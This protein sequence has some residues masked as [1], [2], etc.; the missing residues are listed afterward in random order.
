M[1]HLYFDSSALVKRYIREA[2]TPWISAVCE[3]DSGHMLY[4]VRISGA[5]IVAAF[6]LRVR[7]GTLSILR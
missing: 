1:A 6:F 5:E 4:T 7:T 3:A 2:G